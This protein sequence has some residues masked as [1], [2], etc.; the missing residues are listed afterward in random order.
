MPVAFYHHLGVPPKNPVKP[1][2][3]YITKGLLKGDVIGYSGISGISVFYYLWDKIID[4]KIGVFSFII[5]SKL[6]PYWWQ[7]DGICFAPNV[8]TK[9]IIFLE[10]DDPFARLEGYKFNR[11]WLI[12]SSWQRDGRLDRHS[13]GVREWLE[14]H[15]SVLERKEFDGIFIDLYVKNKPN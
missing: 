12:S 15:Y 6:D 7:R 5:K 14:S 8:I 11:L 1:A 3:D 2:A 9:Y 13:R 10:E 4:E